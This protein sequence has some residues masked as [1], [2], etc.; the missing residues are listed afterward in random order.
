MNVSSIVE[1]LKRKYPGKNIVLNPPDDP[2]EIICEIE[3]ASKNPER[4]VAIAV[5]DETV[6]HY[7]RN[8]KEIY[9]VLK[10]KLK[11]VKDGEEYELQEGKSVVIE[12]GEKHSAEG[13]ETW[14]KVT[15]YPGW[16]IKDH[17]SSNQKNR[18]TK[19]S[20]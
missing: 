8:T 10:G 12:P 17:I 4:S 7:H 13:H 1:E 15:S 5:I 14:I 18:A 6:E 9:E 19:T 16:S 20:S 2:S 3:P 11:V